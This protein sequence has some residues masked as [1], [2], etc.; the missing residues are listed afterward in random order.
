MHNAVGVTEPVA[1]T[2]AS[3]HGR[4]YLVIHADRFVEVSERAIASD[5]VRRWPKRVGSV[6]QW[7]DA[8]DVL[9]YSWKSMLREF[10]K[11]A[12]DLTGQQRA[13]SGYL[14][15]LA[16]ARG[17]GPV[18]P[19]RWGQALTRWN[20]AQKCSLRYLPLPCQRALIPS[21]AGGPSSP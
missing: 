19:M 17:N 14:E 1:E 6:N 18:D 2:V 9:T 8:T 5:M 16:N 20:D 4:P 21:R 12:G 13:V 3:F 11:D 15:L 10:S 7:A